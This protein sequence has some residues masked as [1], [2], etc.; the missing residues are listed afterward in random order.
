MRKSRLFWQR[1]TRQSTASSPRHSGR[2]LPQKILLTWSPSEQNSG[3]NSEECVMV[4]CYDCSEGGRYFQAIKRRQ[5]KTKE[6]LQS[7][8]WQ[9]PACQTFLWPN[10]GQMTVKFISLL[11]WE[12]AGRCRTWSWCLYVEDYT[13]CNILCSQAHLFTDS[14]VSK[15]LFCS[16]QIH[17]HHIL[18]EVATANHLPLACSAGFKPEYAK[19]RHNPPH[20]WGLA[21]AQ[22]V[23]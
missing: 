19:C 6:P 12:K 3:V 21:P 4:G 5:N 10:P 13:F 20:L 17:G 2:N 7:W 18:Y 15:W 22:K 1:E 8:S 16:L 9:W 23:Y 14:Y 11:W